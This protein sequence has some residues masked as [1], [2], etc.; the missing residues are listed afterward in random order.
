MATPESCL[1]RATQKPAEVMV[2]GLLVF[3]LTGVI[4]FPNIFCPKQM[5]IGDN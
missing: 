5:K 4:F 2:R 3:D 1:I